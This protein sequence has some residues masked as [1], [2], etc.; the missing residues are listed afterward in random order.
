MQRGRGILDRA[1]EAEVGIRIGRDD[2]LHAEFAG[3]EVGGIPGDL[4]N[5]G[6]CEGVAVGALDADAGA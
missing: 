6:Q 3:P 2:A 5:L 1:R 4:G